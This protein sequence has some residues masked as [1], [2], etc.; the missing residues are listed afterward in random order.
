MDS[1]FSVGGHLL[2]GTPPFERRASLYSRGP[3]SGPGYAVLDHHHLIDPIRPTR[4]RIAISSHSA[5]TRCL[6]CAGAPRRPATGSGLSLH[7]PSWHAILYRP[8]GLQH[9]QFQT[10]MLTWPSPRDHRLGIPNTPAIR[11]TRGDHFGASTVHTFA[12]ACQFARPPVRIRPVS[13]P[14]GT[15]T[16]RLPACRSPFPP[17]DMTTT[18]TGLLCWRDFHPQE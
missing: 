9:R 6:R 10:A 7:I 1:P 17:L 18:V 8:R 16:S 4:R 13:W 11:F 14:S 5:Y 12:T 15:F 3:R 2:G